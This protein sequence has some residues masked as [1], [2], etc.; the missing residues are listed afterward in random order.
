MAQNARKRNQNPIDKKLNSELA[1]LK[2]E[3][4]QKIR[5]KM[6]EVNQPEYLSA[7]Q[8]ELNLAAEATNEKPQKAKLEEYEYLK[9]MNEAELNAVLL[10]L[11]PVIKLEEKPT[12][13]KCKYML[14]TQVAVLMI[15]TNKIMVRVG[16]GFATIEEHIRQV[17]PFE[18]IK[19]YKIM[20]GNPER[21]QEPM[22]FKNAVAFY[23]ARHKTADKIVK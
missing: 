4:A 17:G 19:I 23:L 13:D 11:L 16:G 14:G 12:A 18:C 8:L 7:K 9:I 6:L 5:D 15:K 21:N 10:A 1:T 3:G 20:K 22:T 2:L